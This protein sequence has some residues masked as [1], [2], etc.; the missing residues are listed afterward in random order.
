[1][2]RLSPK[3]SQPK[4]NQVSST[5]RGWLVLAALCWCLRAAAHGGVFFEED[6]CVIQIDFF[7]AHFTIY[8]PQTRANTEYCEDVPDVTETV[9]VMDYLHDSLK[10]MPVDFRIIRDTDDLGRYARWEDIERIENLDA[11]TVFYQPPVRR[12]DAVFTVEHTF[13]QSGNYIGIV[14]TKHP[15][16]DKTYRAIFPFEV[17]S[18]GFGYVPLFVGL[19]IFVQLNYWLMNGGYTRWRAKRAKSAPTSGA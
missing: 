15:T 2:T 19:A 7:Q 5:L 16:E 12:Y 3:L 14:T 10:E 6:L 18:T 13:E 8:Q 17:G 11:D 4:T 9:F 1:M